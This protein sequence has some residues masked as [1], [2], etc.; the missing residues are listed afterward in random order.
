[1][2]HAIQLKKAYILCCC[3]LSVLLLSACAKAPYTGRNQMII[4]SQEQELALGQDSA[5]QVLQQEKK[6]T[7]TARAKSVERVGR[8][9]AAVAGRDD[10]SWEF[11]TIAKDDVPNAFC[12]PGGKVFVYT[13]L[14]EYAKDDAQLAAVIGHEVGHAIARH[15][16]ERVSIALMAQTGAAVGSIALGVSGAG[17]EMQEIATQAMGVGMNVGV[18]LP[19][20]R[21]Q[22]YEADRVGLI[23][24][25][26][27]GYD[28]H[29]ALNFWKAFAE[30][31]G[32][33]PAEFLSTHP[34]SENRIAAIRDLIPEA[35]QYYKPQN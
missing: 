16:A 13:G 9:I 12:L 4:I 32:E 6:E 11:T 20:S 19:F 1:M 3:A 24:M 30:Q 29:A 10:F 26:K 34:A 27:A 5:K 33:K 8:R 21:T 18:I 2:P 15:G 14:F 17:Q 7:G 31:P 25:A 28:P 22:E 23:L 35:M